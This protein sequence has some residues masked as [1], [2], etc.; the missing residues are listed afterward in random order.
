MPQGLPRL[1]QSQ[2][3][4]RSFQAKQQQQHSVNV[5]QL[6]Q[7]GLKQELKQELKPELKPELKQEAVDEISESEMD[8]E[9]RL[10]NWN[11]RL[12]QVSVKLN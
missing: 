2:V 1:P 9:T 11:R 3:M 6:S 7:E 10:E 4:N 5:S 8:R 12:L